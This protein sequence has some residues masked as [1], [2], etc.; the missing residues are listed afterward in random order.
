MN[1][2][3]ITVIKAIVKTA[4]IMII[5]ANMDIMD[6]T[7]LSSRRGHHSLKAY[8]GHHEQ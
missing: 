2:M 3:D 1:I 5:K 7:V 6:I 8:N 4:D